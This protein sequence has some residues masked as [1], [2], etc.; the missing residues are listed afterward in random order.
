MSTVNKLDVGV[1]KDLDTASE[2]LWCHITSEIDH[3]LT[4]EQ[5]KMKHIRVAKQ[6]EQMLHTDNVGLIRRKKKRKSTALV[7]D[8]VHM[9]ICK[10]DYLLKCQHPCLAKGACVCMIKKKKAPLP[11]TVSGG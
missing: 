6:L 2:Q 7:E 4:L 8:H 3:V 5:S 9:L 11:V 10:L 1:N